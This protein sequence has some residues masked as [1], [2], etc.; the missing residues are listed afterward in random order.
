MDSRQTTDSA[1]GDAERAGEVYQRA[2]LSPARTSLAF[3]PE[4]RLLPTGSKGSNWLP[5]WFERAAAPAGSPDQG[6]QTAW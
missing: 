5:R 3:L 1:A 6:A 2:R 4:A